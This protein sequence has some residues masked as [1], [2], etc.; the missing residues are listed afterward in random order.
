MRFSSLILAAAIGVSAQTAQGAR[1]LASPACAPPPGLTPAP[2]LT[3]R[4]DEV[5]S[6]VT[7][8]YYLLAIS[9]TPQWCRTLGQ[10]GTEQQVECGQPLGFT[11]HGLWPNGA[12]P[13]YPRYCRPVGGLDAGLVRRMYCRTPSAELLQHEWQAHGACAWRDARAYFADSARLFDRVTLPKVE[14]IPAA[15]LTAGA[16]RAAFIAKNPGLRREAVFVATTRGDDLTE[17]RLC[18]DL[19]YKPAACPGGNGAPDGT[20]IHIAPSRTGGF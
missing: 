17:V 13:P 5:V 9:W 14:A 7:T 16:V 1:P 19:K 10:K 12:A 11:L 8:A 6:G 2:V 20:R 15:D 4:P 18:Y 3:P